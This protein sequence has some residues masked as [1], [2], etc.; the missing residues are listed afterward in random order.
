M[1]RDKISDRLGA[2]ALEN[3][4]AARHVAIVPCVRTPG[5][6]ELATMTLAEAFAKLE[7]TK[8]LEVEIIEATED[9]T[10]VAD[11]GLTWRLAQAA[12]AANMAARSGQEDQ[13]EYDLGENGAQV[14]RREREAFDALME[15]IRFSKPGR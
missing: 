3:L 4:F 7:A 14:S 2:D 15:Q 11:E 9:L 12:Q 1:L 13:A 5:D 10:G 8:G 6:T